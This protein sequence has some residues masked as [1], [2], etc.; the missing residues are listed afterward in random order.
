MLNEARG[1]GYVYTFPK[2][3]R[4]RVRRLPALWLSTV[5]CKYVRK[6]FDTS[7]PGLDSLHVLMC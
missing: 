4:A 1:P 6:V 2:L 3:V 5:L 7:W